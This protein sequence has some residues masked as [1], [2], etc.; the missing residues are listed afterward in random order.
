MKYIFLF[1]IGLFIAGISQAQ[2]ILLTNKSKHKTKIIRQGNRV[3]YYVKGHPVKIGRLK[4]IRT[5]SIMIGNEV[6][7]VSDLV[8]LGRK[9]IGSGTIQLFTYA[10]G[11]SFIIVGIAAP[12]TPASVFV[13]GA[14]LLFLSYNTVS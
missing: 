7:A 5:D 4:K 14:G 10:F 1:T 11:L 13:V 8:L 9:R 2:E 12:P 3:A 6:I